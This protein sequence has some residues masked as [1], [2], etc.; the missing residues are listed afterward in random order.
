MKIET[1]E[2]DKLKALIDSGERD[3]LQKF[4]DWLTENHVVLCQLE[5]GRGYRSDGEYVPLR[6]NTENLMAEFFGIDLKKVE[7]EKQ[8]I[9]GGLYT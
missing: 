3:T 6:Q 4:L 1:P 9:L 5:T 2:C 7:R 8:A